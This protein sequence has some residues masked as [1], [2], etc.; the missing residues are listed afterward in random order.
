MKKIKLFFSALLL[1]VL[2]P[3]SAYALDRFV[4][5]TYGNGI[6]LSGKTVEEAK[7]YLEGEY[8]RNYV[9]YIKGRDKVEEIKGSDIGYQ[10]SAAT[11]LEEILKREESL[12]S[13]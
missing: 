5:G 13:I 12:K 9:L 1:S 7:S 4:M 11:N 3:M 8:S 6:P 2:L 10:L